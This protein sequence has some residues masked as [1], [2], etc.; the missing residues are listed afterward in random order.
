MVRRVTA[1]E[2]DA[3]AAVWRQ[4]KTEQGLSPEWTERAVA[5]G[6]LRDALARD[7][8]RIYLATLDGEAI[9]YISTVH[10]PLTGLA[11]LGAD[12]VVCI[13]QLYVR[14]DRRRRGVA[15]ALLDAV[16]G[17]ADLVGAAQIVSCV[18]IS[19]KDTNRW[20]ARLGFG[21]Q[22]NVRTI[23]TAV[24]QARLGGRA[25]GVARRR[26]SERVRAPVRT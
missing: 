4:A 25:E 10:D 15:S 1:G 11:G 5:S 24:L 19:E 17:Y 6:R 21:A 8:V 7:E 13:D 26:V 23:P 9:G 18:M 22:V 2:H 14:P 12:A 20:F 3:L 16:T